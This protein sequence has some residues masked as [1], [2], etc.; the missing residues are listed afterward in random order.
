MAD[1]GEGEGNRGDE[2]R[3]DSETTQCVRKFSVERIRCLGLIA[4]SSLARSFYP[5]CWRRVGKR[6][7]SCRPIY[8]LILWPGVIIWLVPLQGID[9]HT[10]GLGLSG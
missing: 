2:A 5:P 4:F 8:V 7:D 1:G 3:D 9:F 6:R 10:R